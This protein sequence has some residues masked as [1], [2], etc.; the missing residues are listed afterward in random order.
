VLCWKQHKNKGFGGVDNLD[1]VVAFA[2]VVE[3]Q[4]FVEA[5]RE[6]RL[7]SSLISKRVTRLEETLGVQLINR[8]TRRLS[9][10]D[11]G[12]EF[13]KGCSKAFAELDTA[14]IA[15][16]ELSEQLTGRLK[17]HATRGAGQRLLAEGMTEFMS[18]YPDME[19]ELTIESGPVNLLRAGIDVLIRSAELKDSALDFRDL[20]P[21]RYNLCAAPQYLNRCGTPES[22]R[23]L[24]QFNCLIHTGRQHP[25]DWEFTGPDGDY[26]VRVNGNFYTNDGSALYR[27]AM[28]GLGIARVPDYMTNRRDDLQEN[29]L[30]TLLPGTLRWN[31]A[32]RAYFPR[33]RRM[34]MKLQVF[35]DFMQQYWT[36]R[37]NTPRREQRPHSAA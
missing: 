21:I 24:T 10:T 15:A 16:T 28:M 17:V 33:S 25:N 36:E 4:S 5:A 2:R 20:G 14:R 27:A 18:H 35:L 34:P 12:A 26:T 11:A 1:D 9:L 37:A 31:R 19:L 22:P 3:H 23:D 29:R 8:S 6:L 13:Y 32:L 30:R 7:S